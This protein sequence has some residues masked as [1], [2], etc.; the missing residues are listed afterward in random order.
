[1][2]GQMTLSIKCSPNIVSMKR[3]P[4]FDPQYPGMVAHTCVPAS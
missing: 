2:T 1:M 4:E 3:G